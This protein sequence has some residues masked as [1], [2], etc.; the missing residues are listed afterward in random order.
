MWAVCSLAVFGAL[1]FVP[2]S[3]AG[4]LRDEIAGLV[5][6]R[7]WASAENIALVATLFAAL[8]SAVG[9]VIHLAVVDLF[10]RWNGGRPPQ[11]DDY[12]EE[13]SPPTG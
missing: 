5:Q 9:W 2:V 3:Y 1:C 13:P 6:G 10:G 4:S 7:P 12:G 11:A 8:A